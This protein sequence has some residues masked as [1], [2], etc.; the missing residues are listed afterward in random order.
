MKTMSND[1]VIIDAD[2][3]W[4]EAAAEQEASVIRGTLLKFSDWNWF[5]GKESTK[6][7]EGTQLVALST[8]AAW[9]KWADNKPTEYK[10]RATGKDLP[11]REE[12]GDTDESKWPL[13]PDKQP[14]DPWQNTRFVYLLDPKTAE[15]FTYSTSSWG[16]RGAVMDLGSQ[17]SRVRY[18]RPGAVPLVELQAQPH[19]TKFGRKSKPFFKI[20]EWRGDDLGTS[21]PPAPTALPPTAVAENAFSDEIPW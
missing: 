18:A 9:V 16:G 20:I 7:E 11:E 19:I 5:K 6:I 17:I 4:G 13:G 15:A 21:A 14:R 12:L 8:R 2:D 1:L 3:G 10:M